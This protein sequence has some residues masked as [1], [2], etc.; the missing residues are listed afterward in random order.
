MIPR[1]KQLERKARKK[2]AGGEGSNYFDPWG[3][4]V[5]ILR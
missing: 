2:F 4:Q 5:R 3:M 1:R